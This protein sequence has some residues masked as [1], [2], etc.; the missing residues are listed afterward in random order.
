MAA[1]I[2]AC[3]SDRE[4]IRPTDTGI[5]IASEVSIADAGA[6]AF[7]ASDEGGEE[8]ENEAESEAPPGEPCGVH[9]GPPMRRITHPLPYCI[10][11]HEVSNEDYA[12]FLADAKKP[13]LDS[14]CAHDTDRGVPITNAALAQRP[15][16]KIGWC[17][18]L[19]YCLW[20]GKRLCGKIGGGHGSAATFTSPAVDQWSLVCRNG[21]PGQ[22]YP[23][24]PEFVDGMCNQ[25][26]TVVDVNTSWA[27]HG[28]R[29]DTAAVYDMVGNVA[30][31]EDACD[32]YSPSTP[33]GSRRCRVRGGSATTPGVGCDHDR[34]LSMI[35]A[36][37][38]V[39][40]RCCLD[41]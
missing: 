33:P 32:D 37:E 11:V 35:E 19:S 28:T 7:D 16:T 17:D 29:D 4:D 24:G 36:D 6:D 5:P 9:P 26:G 31:W 23:W 18:A 41:L 22:P 1:L 40:F 8:T 10:D 27:C 14:F 21:D 20:A 34:L 25:S 15:A 39:G 13:T 2:V 12:A 30:E 3:A 38:L